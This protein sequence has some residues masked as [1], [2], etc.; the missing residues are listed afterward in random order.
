MNNLPKIVTQL[1][2]R[3][4]FEPTHDL[5]RKFNALPVAPTFRYL[6][7]VRMDR[8]VVFVSESVISEQTWPGCGN[9]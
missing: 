5:D 8:T 4:G 2:P 1:L 3:V 9:V 7:Y 6:V